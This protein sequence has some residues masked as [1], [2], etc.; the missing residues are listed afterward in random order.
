MKNVI[1]YDENVLTLIKKYDMIAV[2]RGKAAKY[3][4]V[5]QT[6]TERCRKEIL[7]E[8]ALI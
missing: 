2:E 7:Y 1:Q 4:L 6:M 8:K 3:S 5:K